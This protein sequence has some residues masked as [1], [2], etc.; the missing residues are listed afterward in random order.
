MK[1]QYQNDFEEFVFN[2]VGAI[3]GLALIVLTVYFGSKGVA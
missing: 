3:F 2:L 1:S